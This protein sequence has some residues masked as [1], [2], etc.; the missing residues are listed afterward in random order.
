[1]VDNTRL[2]AHADLAFELANAS[3]GQ[4]V[5]AVVILR[6]PENEAFP[7]PSWTTTTVEQVVARVSAKTGTLPTKLTVF[8]NLGRFFVSAPAEFVDSLLE[9][10]EVGSALSNRP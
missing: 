5:E 10:S 1:M 8:Q 9:E 6:V 2:K 7:A 4:L 3:A